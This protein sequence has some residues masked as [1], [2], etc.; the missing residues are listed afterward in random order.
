MSEQST[1]SRPNS[2][3]SPRITTGKTVTIGCKMPT[4]LVLRVDE[5]VDATEQV[6]G[7]GARQ[8]K[9]ARQVG[10]P[11]ILN[12]CAVNIADLTS[13]R[14]VGQVVGGFGITTGVP[15][16]FWD[17]WL[18]QHKDDP[19]VVKGI[20]FDAKNDATAHSMARERTP[21]TR[22]GLEPMD[23]QNLPLEFRPRRT[24]GG[25]ITGIQTLTQGNDADNL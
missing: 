6:F 11:V 2:S 14:A 16:D 15:K 20:V 21:S 19:L 1:E 23:P 18:E 17:K 9:V 13:G 3:P 4:G 7:G 12:G 25:G 5:M 10:S 22:S 24:S 8:I